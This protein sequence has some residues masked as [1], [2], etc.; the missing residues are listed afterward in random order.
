MQLRFAVI[1]VVIFGA[2]FLY[3]VY[4][5][6]FHLYTARYGGFPYPSISTAIPIRF[7]GILYYSIYYS[8]VFVAFRLAT[9]Q[10]LFVLLRIQSR[11][12]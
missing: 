5:Y 8:V 12:E 3:C 2:T 4:V 9:P 7:N 6:N 1:Y 11:L 10:T